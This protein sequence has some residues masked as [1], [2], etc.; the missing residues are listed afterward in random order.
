MWRLACITRNV[1]VVLIGVFLA[2]AVV[3]AVGEAMDSPGGWRGVLLA[4]A[5]LAPMGAL[6]VFAWRRPSRASVLLWVLIGMSVAVDAWAS[7]WSDTAHSLEDGAGPVRAVIMFALA[8][9]V[10]PLVAHLWRQA[11]VMLTVLGGAPVLFAA[12]L[13]DVGSEPLLVAAVPTL[14]AGLLLLIAHAVGMRA[15][16]HSAKAPPST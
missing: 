7:M 1:A 13:G 14:V 2:S 15:V 6:L 5:W 4:V 3:F 9:A 11:G 10:L 12:L 16:T 8:G